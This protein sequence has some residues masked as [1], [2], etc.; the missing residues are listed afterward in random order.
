MRFPCRITAALALTVIGLA[1]LTAL[2]QVTC[3][4]TYGGGQRCTDDNGNTTTTRPT[5]GGGYRSTDDNG[6]TVTCTPTYGGGTRC[7]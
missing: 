2:A 7:R 3:T 1:P 6:N 4:P 5:Y